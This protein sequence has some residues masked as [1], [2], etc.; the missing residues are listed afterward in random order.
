M[1]ACQGRGGCGKSTAC[2]ARAGGVRQSSKWKTGGLDSIVKAGEDH[3][4][5]SVIEEIGPDTKCRVC[6]DHDGS[7][8]VW[9]MS[10]GVDLLIRCPFHGVHRQ[11]EKEQVDLEAKVKNL[12][13]F[14][15]EKTLEL[16]LV[17][18]YQRLL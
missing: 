16:A 10:P 5:E 14:V 13:G 9:V 3:R 15:K 18:N 2:V 4:C 11:L 1:A 6:G 12:Q 7:S 8:P 17:P